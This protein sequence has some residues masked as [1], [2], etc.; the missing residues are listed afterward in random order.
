M[1][2]HS[3][4]VLREAPTQMSFVD[5][6]SFCSLLPHLTCRLGTITLGPLPEILILEIY[7]FVVFH[8]SRGTIMSLLPYL[9]T[10]F[11]LDG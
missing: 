2:L 4:Q 3:E 11:T 7:S 8:T 10:I 9:E 1:A 5:S 6:S